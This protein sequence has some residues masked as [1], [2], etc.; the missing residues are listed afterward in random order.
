[1]EK[2]EEVI[3]HMFIGSGKPEEVKA[4]AISKKLASVYITAE[5]IQKAKEYIN[6]GEELAKAALKSFGATEQQHQEAK[7]QKA[8][9]EL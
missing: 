3:I 8:Q 4:F 5:S 7:P 9:E 6:Q 2:P 1:M